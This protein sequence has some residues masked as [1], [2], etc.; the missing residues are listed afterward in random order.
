[1]ALI[2]NRKP[3]RFYPDPKRVIARPFLPGPDSRIKSIIQRIYSLAD[4]EVQTILNQILREFANRHRNISRIFDNNFRRIEHY[5]SSLSLTADDFNRNKKLLIGSYFTLEY[6]IESAAFFNPSIIEDPDQSQVNEGEKRIIVTFRATGEGHISTLVFRGGL[7]DQNNNLHFPSGGRLVDEAEIVRDSVYSKQDFQKKLRE[8]GQMAKCVDETF[9]FLGDDFNYRELN[10]AINRY[11]QET[12]LSPKKIQILASLLWLAD[13]HYE[14]SFSFDTGISERVIFPIADHESN[15]IE[16]ARFVKFTDDDGKTKYYGTYTAYNGTNILPKLIETEDFYSFRTRPIHGEHAHNKG[17]ALFPRKVGGKYAMLARIDGINNYLMFS[18]TIN[19]WDNIVKIQE[20]VFPWEYIQI[21]NCGSPIETERGWL[22]ITHGV[23]PM[24]KYSLGATMLDIDDPTK[25]IAQ[26]SKPLI[27]PNEEE[28]EGYV[29]NVV[30]SC[31]SIIHNGELVI[32]YAMSDTASSFASIPI[33]GLMESLFPDSDSVD[34][35]LVEKD[36]PRILIVEDD[37]VYRKMV[38]NI[39]TQEGYH[40]EESS[41]GMSALMKIGQEKFDLIISD[42]EMPT[43]SG[44]DLI[45]FIKEKEISV[46]VIFM[47]G[48]SEMEAQIREM[49]LGVNDFISKPFE[50]SHLLEIVKRFLT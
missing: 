22:V 40:V 43:I 49:E 39:L 9:D 50:K 42:I 32:P 24:R 26:L 20:P 25:V 34:L 6:S 35:D 29:P 19:N 4:E 31:G 47:S 33:K 15:G 11:K 16:D 12:Q 2:V 28:R 8:M 48:H 30:Y 3:V 37:P 14:I 23:G 1:M 21:G 13:S 10:D 44:L 36:I 17:M 27:A 5:L 7:L 38:N 45:K 41:E 18:D 46:P